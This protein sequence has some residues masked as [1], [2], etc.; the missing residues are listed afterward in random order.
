MLSQQVKV[1]NVRAFLPE[2]TRSNHRRSE[3]FRG[4]RSAISFG[5][6]GDLFRSRSHPSRQAQRT[7]AKASSGPFLRLADADCTNFIHRRPI[8]KQVT[9]SAAPSFLQWKAKLRS[10]LDLSDQ[11][12]QTESFSASKDGWLKLA[13]LLLVAT[14]PPAWMSRDRA[15]WY[16]RDQVDGYRNARASLSSIWRFCAMVFGPRSRL[17]MGS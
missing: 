15:D 5:L 14:R 7:L 11:P 2:R 17:K 8:P 4:A 13:H 1:P 9:L 6:I 10:P 3:R 12:Q 16:S